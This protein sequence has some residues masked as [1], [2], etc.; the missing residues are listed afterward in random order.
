MPTLSKNL[1]QSQ[2][3]RN[4]NH[5]TRLALHTLLS[6]L[7]L[8]KQESSIAQ[9]DHLRMAEK[10]CAVVVRLLEDY[11]GAERGR[12]KTA[13]SPGEGTTVLANASVPVASALDLPFIPGNEFKKFELLMQTGQLLRVEEWSEDLGEVY[14]ELTDVA[15]ALGY[16][17][18][19]ADLTSLHVVLERWRNKLG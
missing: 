11:E 5:E 17:A 1:N 8:A 9:L 4:F 19:A 10:C 15:D 3:W 16:Y 2:A 7:Q 12:L 13:E 18:S 14:P 6:C